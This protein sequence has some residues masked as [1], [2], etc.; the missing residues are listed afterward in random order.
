MAVNHIENPKGPADESRPFIK[1][2]ELRNV[3]LD[4]LMPLIRESLA[5]GQDVRFYPRGVSMLPMLRQGVDS[6]VLSPVR[7]PLERYDIPLYQRDCGSYV[8][9]RVVKVRQDGAGSTY[10]CSGDHQF[11]IE[12]GIRH[13]QVIA[14]VSGFYRG[15]QYYNVTDAKYRMYCWALH[16][17]RGLRHFRWRCIGFARRLKRK[18]STR[19]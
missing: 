8:L 2:A 6:V 19:R 9:H 14:V 7:G 15:N 5:A 4:D 17:S 10:D 18:L 13:D 3:P 12:R 16:H 1:K 11:A